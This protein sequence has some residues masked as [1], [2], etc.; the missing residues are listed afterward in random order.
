M[1]AV[2]P[3]WNCLYHSHICPTPNLAPTSSHPQLSFHRIFR[4]YYLV[5]IVMS[6]IILLQIFQD[7]AQAS[8]K[9]SLPLDFLFHCPFCVFM[10][11]NLCCYPNVYHTVIRGLQIW[12]LHLAQRF[13]MAENLFNPYGTAPSTW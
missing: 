3:A 6:K 10:V 8:G 2:L 4:I 13:I 9:P 7:S 12:T 11:T 1:S 5:H